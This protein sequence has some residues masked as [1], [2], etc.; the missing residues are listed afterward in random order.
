MEMRNFS[1]D[2]KI[3]PILSYASGA[4]DRT[5]NVI[6]TKGFDGF[7]VVVH[8]AA[9]H[10]SATL[11][12]YLQHAD[13]A[14]NSTT[15]TSGADVATSSQTIGGTDDNKAIFIDVTSPT[16]RFYQLVVDNDGTNATAQSAVAYLY[17]R[18]TTAPVTHATG[19]GTSEGTGAVTGELMVAPTS[20]TK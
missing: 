17:R 2:V 15:L 7:C 14:S 1:K 18:S 5:S 4:T 12:M 9:V 10:D 8:H 16:K 3:V 6:D 20:G 19:S 11:A 13:A